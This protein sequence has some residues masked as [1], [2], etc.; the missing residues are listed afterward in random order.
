MTAAIARRITPARARAILRE[1][2]GGIA[3]SFAFR[4]WDGSEVRVGPEP[5]V[6]TAVIK[7]PEIFLELMR[8]PSPYRF[9]VAYVESAIDLEGDLFAAMDVANAVERIRVTPWQRL[10]LF[11]SLWTR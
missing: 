10:R 2:F 5:P 7:D 4:L 11:V 3:A 8:D 9:A 6:A 1:V